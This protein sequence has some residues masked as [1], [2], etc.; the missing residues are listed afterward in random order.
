MVLLIEDYILKLVSNFVLIGYVDS[1]FTSDKD[2]ENQALNI[3]LLCWKLSQLQPVLALS[4]TKVEYIAATE[5]V[6]ELR[7]VI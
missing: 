6:K 7:S 1:D 5:A 4:T 2:T 3:S